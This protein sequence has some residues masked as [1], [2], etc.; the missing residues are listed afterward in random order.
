[1]DGRGWSIWAWM[2]PAAVHA[3]HSFVSLDQDTDG[4]TVRFANGATDRA[5]VV[6]GADRN[7]SAVR[8]YVFP[9]EPPRRVDESDRLQ[10]DRRVGGGRLV[11]PRNGRAVPRRIRWRLRTLW[12]GTRHR[13]VEHRGPGSRQLPGR[14]RRAGEQRRSLVAGRGPGP[15]RPHHPQPGRRWLRPTRLQPGDGAGRLIQ[16]G[17]I[18]TGSTAAVAYRPKP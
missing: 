18:R 7:G 14:A 3:A 2:H 5:P 13:G 11:D 17:L 10:A 4:V 8:S 12:C 6:V 15:T 1:M 16:T 9:G